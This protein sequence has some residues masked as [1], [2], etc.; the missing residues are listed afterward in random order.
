MTVSGERDA[1]VKRSSELAQ[2]LNDLERQLV[3]QQL[4]A[5]K[6]L[7]DALGSAASREQEYAAQVSELA[8]MMEG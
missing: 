6:D 7:D 1:I 2:R 4:R 8:R 3:D 5:K